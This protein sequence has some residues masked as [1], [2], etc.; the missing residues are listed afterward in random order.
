ML[1]KA[2]MGRERPLCG[3]GGRRGHPFAHTQ[4]P[5]GIHWHG[6]SELRAK[7]GDRETGAA[8]CPGWGGGLLVRLRK[9]VGNDGRGDSE[10]KRPR[11]SRRD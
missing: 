4:L 8:K 2:L 6:C 10:E 1:M 3:P 11:R 9:G 5:F 7:N